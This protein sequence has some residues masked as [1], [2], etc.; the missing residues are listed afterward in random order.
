MKPSFLFSGKMILAAITAFLCSS[1]T[2]YSQESVKGH[3]DWMS[4]NKQTLSSFPVN[5][6]PILGAHDA[7]SCYLTEDSPHE[8]GAGGCFL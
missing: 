3:P 1:P 6:V 4:Q 2:S 8:P 7:S 5:K